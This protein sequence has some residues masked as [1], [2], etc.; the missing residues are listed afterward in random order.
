MNILIVDDQ[1]TIVDSLKNGLNWEKI[2]IGN[3]Y[4][5]YG[6]REAKLVLMNFDVDILLT[7]IEMPEED[8]IALF[9]WAKHKIP[10]IVGI[11]LTSHADFEYARNA[12]K[13]GSFD[14]ILQPAHYSEVEAVL[15]RGVEEARKKV[16]LKRL[17][18]A[19]EAIENQR[20]AALEMLVAKLD[21][22]NE[23]ECQ[24][25][26]G[27]LREMFVTEFEN[28]TFQVFQI[29]LLYFE[30]KTNK[31]DNDLIKLVFR[32]V[33]EELFEDV[34]AKACI[35]NCD[36]NRYI[37][38]LAHEEHAIGKDAWRQR[39]EEFT[40]FFNRR[41]GFKIA[42]YPIQSEV[43]SYQHDANL[44]FSAAE[45]RSSH[46]RGGVY[47]Q[48][49]EEF[50]T[51]EN[52]DRI[53]AA[54]EY[55]KSNISKNVTR[56]QVAG[57]VHL[58]EEYFSRQFKKYTGYTYKDYDIMVRMETAKRLLEQTRLSI[59]II[60]SKVGYDN[61]SH[62]SKAFKKYTDA[63]PQEYRKQKTGR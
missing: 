20:D 1:K 38:F 18:R 58:N 26:F 7:D 37:I 3:V 28:C 50:S 29:E 9:Q 60:A 8:G 41:M 6:S 5:A 49:D 24:N 40:G 59:S 10:G 25:I 61:F 19:T 62:F 17:E 33:L 21:Q 52:A 57:Y 55:I 35:G 34:H 16:R 45:A 53:R 54:E 14:Y 43:C 47:W 51:D 42:V 39:I 46:N 32:N 44:M 27:R 13:L 36:I 30:N 56:T 12:I 22:E 31:W 4:T 48:D 23:A 11:F 15:I 63:T 2:G